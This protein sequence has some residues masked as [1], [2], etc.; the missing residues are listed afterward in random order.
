MKIYTKKGDL[1]E[2]S[3]LGGNRVSKDHIR[4]ESYGTVD[5]LN[6]QIGLVMCS[7]EAARPVLKKVQDQLF[8]LGSHLAN[9]ANSQFKL[10]EFNTSWVIELET[11]IDRMT[12]E[13][14]ELKNFVLP[15]SDMA[16]AH[17]HVARCICRRAERLVVALHKIEPVDTSI[18]TYLNRLSDFLFTLSRF[19]T[20]NMG[21]QEIVWESR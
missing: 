7:Y 10:P 16:N 18:I 12:S 8:T 9:G 3:L 11:E 6:A 15:G 21:S 4:I 2:T 5:E 17:C 19:I 13:L 1:G 14:A 20:Y